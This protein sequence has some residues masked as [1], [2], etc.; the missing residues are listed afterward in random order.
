MRRRRPP[1]P[2]TP[3]TYTFQQT[4]YSAWVSTASS[5]SASTLTATGWG[6]RTWTGNVLPQTYY[7]STGTGERN[8]LQGAAFGTGSI[9]TGTSTGT[10]T[11]SVYGV[12]GSTLTGTA[13]YN[14]IS[15]FGETSNYTGTVVI[16]PSGQMTF[17]YA[18]G[19][20]SSASTFADGLRDH[21]SLPPGTYFTQTLDGAMQSTSTS[22]LIPPYYLPYNTSSISTLWGGG[23]STGALSGNFAATLTGTDTSPWAYDYRPYELNNLTGTVAGRVEPR[24]RGNPGGGPDHL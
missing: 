8:F 2:P 6:T 23:S 10:L 1:P 12:L 9:S 14:G 15:S 21:P 17:T 22:T 7:T 20:I 18:D 24:R 13:T 16:D 19:R 11:G 3:G 4:G 5:T